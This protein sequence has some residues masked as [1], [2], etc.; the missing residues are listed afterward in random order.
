VAWSWCLGT[1]K[2]RLLSAWPVLAV[3]DH[4]QTGGAVVGGV[5]LIEPH[6]EGNRGPVAPGQRRDSAPAADRVSR[7]LVRVSGGW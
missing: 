3:L 2:P 1:G 5:Q 7:S 4:R 6:L